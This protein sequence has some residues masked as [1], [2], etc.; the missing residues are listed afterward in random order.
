MKVYPI[1][2]YVKKPVVLMQDQGKFP[3]I[4][5]DYGKIFEQNGTAGD[6]CES[7]ERFEFYRRAKEAY[8]VIYTGE[9]E[10]CA[11]IIIQKGVVTEA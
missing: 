3:S 1:D 11:N 10:L 8:A 5:R 7:A 2:E 6:F 4:W 9:T